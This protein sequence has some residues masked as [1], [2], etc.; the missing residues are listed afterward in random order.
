MNVHFH[1]LTMEE[2]MNQANVPEVKSY[3]LLSQMAKS[4]ADEIRNPLAGIAGTVSLLRD[5]LD[6]KSDDGKLKVIDDCIAR[7]DSFIEDLYLLTRPIKPCFIKINIGSFVQQVA[8]YY[9]G[10][11][12][13]NYRFTKM[14][15][16]LYVLADIVLLQQALTNVLDNA[17]DAI[18]EHGRITLSVQKRT[19]AMHFP[20]MASITIADTGPGMDEETLEKIFTPFFTTKHNGRGLGLVITHNYIAFHKGSIQVRSKKYHGT[21]V[22]LD[23]PLSSGGVNGGTR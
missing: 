19:G 18:S 7:I 14:E 17:V 22:I 23:L 8:Q 10:N 6:L 13:V 2:K 1:T 16:D 20:K 9:L 15:K 21:E 5:E 4:I 12:S 3:N 11:K